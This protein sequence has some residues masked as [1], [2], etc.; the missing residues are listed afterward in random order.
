MP[1]FTACFTWHSER[2]IYTRRAAN[3]NTDAFDAPH[4]LTRIVE[5][6]EP[7]GQREFTRSSRFKLV[8]VTKQIQG[9]YGNGTS[10][11]E[12][13]PQTFRLIRILTWRRRKAK[14]ETNPSRA[15]CI[16]Q[17]PSTRGKAIQDLNYVYDPSGNVLQVQDRAKDTKYF[18]NNRVD[19]ISEYTYDALYR[20]NEA[21]GREH[22]SQRSIIGRAGT[23]THFSGLSDPN[24]RT[25]SDKDGNALGRY[26]ENYEYDAVG[27][28]L[29]MRHNSSGGNHW[30][31]KYFYEET[32]LVPSEHGRLHGNRLSATSI[33]STTEHYRYDTHGNIIAMAHLP[34]M[35]WNFKDQLR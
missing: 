27:N 20:L 22:L 12:Y 30:T 4:I 15:L 11:N 10:H 18:Q 33:G 29:C 9:S 6:K 23:P 14:S 32:S 24:A 35:E 34:H 3:G 26:M 19:A 2:W 8:S 7:L 25:I 17:N 13:D 21:T 16:S 28:I 31:R 5:V 1:L